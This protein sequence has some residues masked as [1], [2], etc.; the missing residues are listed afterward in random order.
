VS[1]RYHLDENI[2]KRLREAAPTTAREDIAFILRHPRLFAHVAKL[3]VRGALNTIRSDPTLGWLKSSDK[4]RAVIPDAILGAEWGGIDTF[5]ALVKQH[6]SSIDRCVEIG[7]GGGRITHLVRPLV[8]ELVAMDVS[9]TMLEEAR[10]GGGNDVRYEVVEGFGNNLAAGAYS[11]AV[12]HDVFVH[13]DYDD[14]GVYLVNLHRSLRPG[15]R[16]VVSVYTLDSP[17]ERET[18]RLQLVPKAGHARRIRMLPAAAYEMLFETLGFEVLDAV[19][20]SNNEYAGAKTFGHLN[21]VL[22]RP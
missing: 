9:L 7:C 8:S 5:M 1:Q 17:A 16:F 18:Y 15:G 6:A 14:V 21:Y 11:L 22:R 10:R 13:F 12:S 3:G 19:R 4:V 2:Q 20:T